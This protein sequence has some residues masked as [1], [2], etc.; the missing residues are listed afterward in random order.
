MTTTSCISSPTPPSPVNRQSPIAR[1]N[2]RLRHLETAKPTSKWCQSHRARPCSR[3]LTD[4]CPRCPSS[5]CAARTSQKRIHAWAQCHQ[6]WVCVILQLN[7][8]MHMLDN[9]QEEHGLTNP[10]QVAGHRLD[11]AYKVVRRWSRSYGSVWISRYVKARR[12]M[13]ARET[14]S[15]TQQRDKNQKK[16]NINYHLSRMYPNIVGPHKRT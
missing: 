11:T 8:A 2:P 6:C 15:N 16:N 3:S 5:A 12:S 10:P 7:E 1:R 13:C 4:H 9:S 14:R